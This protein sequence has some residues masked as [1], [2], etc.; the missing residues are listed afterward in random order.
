MHS[1]HSS[2]AFEKKRQLCEQKQT[3]VKPSMFEKDKYDKP[4]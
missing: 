1:T 3:C 2:V 4:N